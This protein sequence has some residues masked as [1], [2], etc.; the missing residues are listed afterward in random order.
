MKPQDSNDVKLPISDLHKDDL[1][2]NVNRFGPNLGVYKKSMR[3]TK[4][5]KP[6]SLIP[7]KYKSISKVQ[8]ISHLQEKSSELL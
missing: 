3:P 7:R 8:K 6:L 4:S 2:I 1:P 5:L